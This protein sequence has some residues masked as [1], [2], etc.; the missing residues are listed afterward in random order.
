LEQKL[1]ES[2]DKCQAITD[3]PQLIGD[4]GFV[5]VDNFPEYALEAGKSMLDEMRRHT[6]GEALENFRRDQLGIDP[7]LLPG[8][9]A[10]Y[11]LRQTLMHLG[12][13]YDDGRKLLVIKDD[14]DS[15][16]IFMRVCIYRFPFHEYT[17]NPR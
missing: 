5:D 3:I 1:G 16:A 7:H 15:T 2:L 6:F 13:H 12:Q 11:D 4:T 14:A 8:K 10:F 9:Q 17:V